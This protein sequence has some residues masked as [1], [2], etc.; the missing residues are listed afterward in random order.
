MAAGTANLRGANSR[1]LLARYDVNGALD[2]TF[3]GDGKVT[4]I[5]A[6][7]DLAYSVAIQPSDD[8]IVAVGRASGQ[9]GRIGPAGYQMN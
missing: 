1:F 8:R 5:S 6:G 7:A 2:T 3:G 4:S 9:G